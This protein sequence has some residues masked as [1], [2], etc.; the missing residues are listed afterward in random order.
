DL[1]KTTTEH[2]RLLA[3]EKGLPLTCSCGRDI[4]VY[5]DPMR[6]KQVLVNLIDNAIKYTP[7]GELT[8]HAEEDEFFGG[9]EPSSPSLPAQ[10]AIDVSITVSGSMANLQIADHG[11]GIS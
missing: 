9:S 8:E 10:G 1:I 4:Y 6:M 5:A 7:P 3:E 11:I 2:M